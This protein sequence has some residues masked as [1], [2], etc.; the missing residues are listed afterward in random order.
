MSLQYAIATDRGL[1]RQNNEDYARAELD[2]A[3]FVIADGMGGHVAGEVASRVAVETVFSLV[4]ERPKPRR[5]RDE[6]SLLGEATIAA[7][8]A[9]LR[10]AE[11]K[12]LPGM[13]TTLTALRVR[14]RTA[15]VAHIGDT[16]AYF[17]KPSELRAITRDHT[18][19]AMLV[20]SDLV[21][22]EDTMDHPEKHILTQAIGTQE[23]VEPEIVQARIPR[24]ARILL[25]TDGLHDVVP[26]EEIHEL[27]TQSGLDDAVGRLVSAAN[28]R[29]GPDNITV[30][31]VEP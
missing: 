30:I 10:E 3:L 29:G 23:L 28:K 7:N 11:A 17:V 5:I 16:R 12:S 4:K 26:A 1:E 21:R 24:G 18:L 14:G 22:P 13:G 8:T 2:L 20:E 9:V 6:P 27:A 15:T 31:L 25:S 19:V